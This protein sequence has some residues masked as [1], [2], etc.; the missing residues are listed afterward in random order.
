MTSISITVA[1]PLLNVASIVIL[2]HYGQ[3][4]RP[5][6][7]PIV[8]A[9]V[10]NTVIVSI[11]AG[12]LFNYSGLPLAQTADNILKILGGSSLPLAPA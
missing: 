5:G 7:L 10:K 12:L 3:G 8:K 4:S 6:W 9:L 2:M 11:L 1:I